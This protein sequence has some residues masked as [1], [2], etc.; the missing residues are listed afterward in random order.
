MD[1]NKGRLGA[2]CFAIAPPAP[3]VLPMRLGAVLSWRLRLGA[4]RCY[5]RS[6]MRDV[7]RLQHRNTRY[8]TSRSQRA[9]TSPLRSGAS[10]RAFARCR[11]PLEE[12]RI[13][14]R[15]NTASRRKETDT[16]HSS[17][18]NFA[19]SENARE[20]APASVRRKKTLDFPH[21]RIALTIAPCT[22]IG[23][24]CEPSRI[25]AVMTA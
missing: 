6:A 13:R 19:R 15:K 2:L 16:V 14:S 11:T 25:H 18:R 12:P 10:Q 9:F 17:E 22:R 24:V 4:D 21:G 8:R 5:G 3:F 1:R 23:A 20:R 7:A